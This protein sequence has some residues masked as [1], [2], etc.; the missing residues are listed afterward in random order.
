[1]TFPLNQTFTQL[2]NDPVHEE[3]DCILKGL[4]HRVCVLFHLPV[5]A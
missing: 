4:V 3:T 1:M 5:I 2:V